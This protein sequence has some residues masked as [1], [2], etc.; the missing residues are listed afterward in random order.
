MCG[1]PYVTG[2]RKNHSGSDYD[3]KGSKR[4]VFKSPTNKNKLGQSPTVG[5]R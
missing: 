1:F 4:G 2:G 5:G 3:P